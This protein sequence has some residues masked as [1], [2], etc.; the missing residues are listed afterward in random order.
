MPNKM[1]NLIKNV[2]DELVEMEAHQ[3]IKQAIQEVLQD[4]IG[5]KKTMYDWETKQ[6]A[7]ECTGHNHKRQEII[8]KAKKDYGINIK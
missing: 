8:K 4:V 1:D 6:E 2:Y 3:A 5:R 7:N